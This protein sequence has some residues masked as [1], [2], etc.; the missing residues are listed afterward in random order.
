MFVIDKGLILN[1]NY[2]KIVNNVTILTLKHGIKIISLPEIRKNLNK[3][4][5]LEYW[6][7]VFSNNFNDK[8]WYIFFYKKI[9][10]MNNFINERSYHLINSFHKI[11]IKYLEKNNDNSQR[12]FS[13]LSNLYQQL[14]IN[15]NFKKIYGF[16]LFHSLMFQ[17]I[18]FNFSSCV[19]CNQI[20]SLY[21]INYNLGGIFCKN[22]TWKLSVTDF[23]ISLFKK[24][25][26]LY[27]LNYQDINKWQVANHE[28]NKIII[29]LENHCQKYNN[30]LFFL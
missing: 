5:V 22:C 29:I 2:L 23:D 18:Q 21:M 4:N 28:I 27:F 16:F 30:K 14:M 20:T 24:I 7:L 10:K 17:G 6:I 11:A 1:I 8:N 9:K 3:Y 13:F 26:Q 25:Y 15:S 19:N 12:V